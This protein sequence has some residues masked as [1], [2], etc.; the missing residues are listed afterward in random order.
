[1]R[2]T[3]KILAWVLLV[4]MILG[5]LP[6]AAIPVRAEETG[7]AV[8]ANAMDYGADP[9]GATDSAEAI[10]AALAAAKELEAAGCPPPTIPSTRTSPSKA[11]PST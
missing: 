7:T 2:T 9:A 6:S 10:Q 11:T 5:L 1:M 4:C 8:V 3:R